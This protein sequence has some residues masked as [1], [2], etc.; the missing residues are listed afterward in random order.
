MSNDEERAAK[1]WWRTMSKTYTTYVPPRVRLIMISICEWLNDGRNMKEV[2]ETRK[3]IAEI[4]GIEKVIDGF[5]PMYFSRL[6]AISDIV[7]RYVSPA[8]KNAAS[9]LRL[10]ALIVVAVQGK[11]TVTRP[12]W[13]EG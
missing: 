10:G 7:D 1:G 9:W 6:M 4:H 3:R 8:L 2:A 12:S 5:S 13:P 11:G